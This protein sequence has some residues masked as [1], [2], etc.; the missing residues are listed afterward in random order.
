MPQ[1]PGVRD[2]ILDA[3]S[4][5]LP[6][7]CAGCGAPDRALCGACRAGLDARPQRLELG[8]TIVTAALRYEGAVRSGIL[9]FKEQGRT[10]T[11]RALAVPLR[12]AI[13]TAAHEAA[14]RGGPVELC[15]MPGS[16]AS[17]RRRG[18]D[19]LALLLRH[20]GFGR[21]VMLLRH[22]RRRGEQKGLGQQQR[23]ENVAHS[24]A[25]QA[26][27][28]GRRLLLVDDIVTTGAT[29]AEAAR[30][31]RTAGGIV[32]GAAVLAATPRHSREAG[33]GP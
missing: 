27:L 32:T 29:L 19:P 17:W 24:L 8:G 1:H 7:D 11:A 33:E 31:V 18:F 2:A 30:A 21:P 12:V 6:V 5:L 15:V 14:Q 9:A 10:D 16:A 3:L 13:E 28:R 4:V 22:E 25:A 26:P 23:V 20:G